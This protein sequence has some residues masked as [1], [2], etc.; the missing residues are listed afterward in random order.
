MADFAKA[1][2]IDKEPAFAWWIPYTLQKCDILISAI[3]IRIR[4]TT[5]KYGI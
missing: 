2:G 1:C 4:K 5:H 3:N